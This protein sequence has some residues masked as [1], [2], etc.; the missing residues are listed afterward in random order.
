M[1]DTIKL[2]VNEERVVIK[3]A[4]V[5]RYIRDIPQAEGLES[6]EDSPLIDVFFN[7]P[8]GYYNYHSGKYGGSYL[9]INPAIFNY[10]INYYPVSHQ[11][12]CKVIEFIEEDLKNRGLSINLSSCPVSRIDVF[13]QFELNNPVPE[14]IGALSGS[15]EGL[16]KYL[17][18]KALINQSTLYFQNNSKNP[19]RVIRF[20]DKVQ[21]IKDKSKGFDMSSLKDIN[22]LRVEY[23]LQSKKQVVSQF[24]IKRV[25]DIL[26]DVNFK[27]LKMLYN[28]FI[29]DYL[30]PVLYSSKEA[31]EGLEGLNM[32]EYKRISEDKKLIDITSRISMLY[33]R[34]K[35]LPFDYIRD[36]LKKNNISDYNIKKLKTLYQSIILDKG[37]VSLIEEV[38]NK[39]KYKKVA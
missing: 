22:S 21:A 15:T 26:S 16:K 33:F 18:Y 5:K 27:G 37:S 35:G 23:S 2:K 36:V 20:Y 14:Y 17:S 13:N 29:E 12:F 32:I 39:V 31:V 28:D 24:S 25:N 8:E 7:H 19:S 4:E 30:E 10:G 6:F 1:I 38:L 3:G 9:D 11:G 34:E